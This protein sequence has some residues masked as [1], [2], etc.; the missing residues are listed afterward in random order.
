MSNFIK[1]CESRY[2][3]RTCIYHYVNVNQIVEL[4][5]EQT[6]TEINVEATLTNGMRVIILD[7]KSL[8]DLVGDEVDKIATEINEIK[9]E[10][11][12]GRHY[13]N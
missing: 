8:K 12:E 13:G 10:L 11:K 3:N 5:I 7:R 6:Q 4:H 2:G 1:V 9:S